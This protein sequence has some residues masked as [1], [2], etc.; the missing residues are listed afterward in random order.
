[1]ALHSSKK[2]KNGARTPER[3]LHCS[4]IKSK[5]RSVRFSFFPGIF[6]TIDS[7]SKLVFD[8]W[9]ENNGGS[10]HESYAMR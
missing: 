2:S 4:W 9:V 10:S 8:A 1:M 5:L 3:R 7:H 6:S